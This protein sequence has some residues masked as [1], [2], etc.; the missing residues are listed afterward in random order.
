MQLVFPMLQHWRWEW[1]TVSDYVAEKL[2]SYNVYY[3]IVYVHVRPGYNLCFANSVP[4]T[5]EYKTKFCQF[6]CQVPHTPYHIHIF[7]TLRWCIQLYIC[8]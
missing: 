5:S 1:C 3:W 4:S 6:V 2:C 7:V 8:M